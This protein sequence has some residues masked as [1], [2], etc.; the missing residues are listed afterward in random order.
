MSGLRL[1][2]WRGYQH[3]FA[4]PST[5]PSIAGISGGSTSGTMAAFLSAETVMS[6]QNTGKEH[7]LTYLFLE[8]LADSLRRPIVWLEYRPPLVR[9]GAP[10]TSRFAIVTP[11]TADRSGGPFEMM[12][13]AINEYRAAIG[14][15]PIAPW[16]RSRICTTY[17][18]TRLARRYVEAAGWKEHDELVGL[19][20]DEPDRVD[21]LRVGVPR[22][23]GRFAPLSQAGFTLQDITD[24]WST[25]DFRLGLAPHLGN[26]TGCFLKDQ[27]D[28]SRALYEMGDVVFWATLQARYP[29]FGGVNHAGYRQLAAEAPARMA[30][31]NALRGD[32]E[33]EN[34]GSMNP[35]R[36]RLVVIQERK[37][38]AGQ[39][40]AFSCSCEGSDALSQMDSDEENAYIASLPSEDEAA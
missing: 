27:T 24:F 23:I 39:V 10:A 13:M 40:A 5:R 17:M 12:M 19:R 21:R 36:F 22:R 9:G 31:E 14:K 33:P 1:D 3:L 25:Q 26:C 38:I 32:R 16:W 28:L 30:I 2:G 15:G 29:G 35:R 4:P 20:A 11:A 8:R 37:R 18:K 7:P 6:F 34:D